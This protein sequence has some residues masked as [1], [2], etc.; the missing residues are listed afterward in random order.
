MRSSPLFVFA[1]TGALLVTLHACS[2]PGEAAET[3]DASADA[4]EAGDADAGEAD[5]K[6]AATM[7]TL[8]SI[9]ARAVGRHGGDLQVTVQGDDPTLTAYAAHIRVRDAQS[10]KVLA[11][12]G[13]WN[14]P[15]PGVPGA[16]AAERRV[17][18]DPDGAPAQRMFT[19]TITLPGILEA[20]PTIARIDFAVLTAGDRHS[21]KFF[22]DVTPQAVVTAGKTC[23]P[24]LLVDRCAA[25]LACA[26][27]PPTCTAA[28]APTLSQLAY[29]PGPDGPHMLF[30]GRDPAGVIKGVHVELLQGSGAPATIDLGNGN[31]VTSQDIS[32]G[33]AGSFGA[34]FFDQV[35]PLGFE[36]IVARLAATPTGPGVDG[37]TRSTAKFGAPPLKPAGQ[38]CD[39]RG[40]LGCAAGNACMHDAATGTDTCVER[41]MA[42]T[43]LLAAAPAIDV[44]KGQSF[45][46]GYARGT[47]FWDPPPDCLAASAMGRPEGVVRLHLAQAVAS[48]T[49]STTVEETSFD[50]I[51][52]LLPGAGGTEDT[53]VGC[54]D[55]ASGTASSITVTSL[56]PGDY[57]IVVDSRSM[58]GGKFGVKVQ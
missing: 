50:T 5:A 31:F 57:T 55:D 49:I 30:E 24:A 48:L 46:T 54:N 16:P 11:F 39:V 40:F 45:A 19:R 10:N 29:V 43:G 51:L 14:G 26:G 56:Q 22:V 13:N 4:N 18:F 2:A 41:G 47:S 9:V 8:T 37:G 58:S 32:F 33:G 36:G 42:K 25:G 20:F 23:D 52:Y 35:A 3:S 34:I 6:P 12:P 1:G 28:E 27:S 15:E 38:P 21:H 17:L 44:S 7:A 53:P